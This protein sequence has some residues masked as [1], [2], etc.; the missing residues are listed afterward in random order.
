MPDAPVPGFGVDLHAQ[1]VPVPLAFGEPHGGGRHG[2][3]GIAV[4]QRGFAGYQ[5]AQEAGAMVESCG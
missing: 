3:M 1:P 5:R 2:L 4:Q